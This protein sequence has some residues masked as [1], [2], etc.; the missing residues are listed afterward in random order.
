MKMDTIFTVREAEKNDIPGKGIARLHPEDMFGLELNPGDVVQLQGA[1]ITT[2][3]VVPAKTE[4]RENGTIQADGFTR[5]NAGASIGEVVDVTKVEPPEAKSIVLK[6][7][8]NRVIPQGSAQAIKAHLMQMPV[9]TG[10]ILR[11][12]PFGNNAFEFE[13]TNMEPEPSC[14]IGHGTRVNLEIKTP[15]DDGVTTYEDIGGLSRQIAEVRQVMELPLRHP[16]VFQALGI[17][18]PKGVL[19]TGPPGC[20]KTML[21]RA[22][23]GAIGATFFSISGPEVMNKFVGVSAAN[24]RKLFEEAATKA[25]VIIFIDELDSMAPKRESLDVGGAA[26]EQHKNVV[27]QLC[28][29]M[30]G[31]NARGRVMVIAAT[32][33]PDLIDPA[34]RRPGR[35]DS[36]IEIGVPDE[37][38]RLEI[39][40][41][42]TRAMPLSNDIRLSEM[43]AITHGFT[44]ADLAFAA[45]RAAMAVISRLLPDIDMETSMIPPAQLAELVVTKA[46]FLSAIHTIVPSAMREV[47]L[48]SPDIFWDDVGGLEDAKLALQQAVIWPLE[49][50]DLFRYMDVSSLRGVLMHGAPGTGKTLLVKALAHESAVNLILIKGPALMSRWVGETEKGVRE[51]FKKA[52]QSAPCIIFIDEVDAVAPIR[53]NDNSPVA[54]RALTQLLTEMDGMED[55][56]QVVI[57]AATNRIDLVDPALLRSGRCDIIIELP[58]PDE[59][60]RQAIFDIHTKDKPMAESVDLGVLVRSTD[61]LSG[62]DI[63]N[64]CQQAALAAIGEFVESG[65]ED[66]THCLIQQAHFVSA[67]EAIIGGSA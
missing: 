59:N 55:L 67:I 61:G 60:A 12:T 51:V 48:E 31:L 29:L 28:T 39:L 17:E 30:D 35:F 45:K 64:I 5:E 24:L 9:C 27:T 43:A 4:S 50:A 14:L 36:E 63:A 19:L 21:A 25:P 33:L 20:G 41:I 53:G 38:G 16:E 49:H 66:K 11:V 23:A 56:G 32:N 8:G 42:H 3:K 22:L 26:A 47:Y 44:G 1:K 58:L 40:E 46:D 37:D 2:V 10:N 6:P 13:V 52:R 57:V 15:V 65:R 18:P 34:L 62:A 7:L 54:D